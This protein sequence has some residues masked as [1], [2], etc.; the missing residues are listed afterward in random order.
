MV[1]RGKGAVTPSS[2]LARKPVEAYLTLQGRFRYLFEPTRP[3]EAI[4]HIQER[5]DAYW[6]QV[7]G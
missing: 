6:K 3:D 5:V 1:E 4:R 2:I 7:N